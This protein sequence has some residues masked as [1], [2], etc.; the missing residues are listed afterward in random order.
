[1][2]PSALGERYL[3]LPGLPSWPASSDGLTL[4]GLLCTGYLF[5]IRP[6]LAAVL[7]AWGARTDRTWTIPAGAMLAL[8]V[9]WISG[10]SIRAAIPAV[11]RMRPAAST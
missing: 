6:P 10:L 9:L 8:T 7:V 2:E 11:Q 5:V 4:A 3:D 1:M